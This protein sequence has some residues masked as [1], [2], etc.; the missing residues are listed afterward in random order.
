MFA[1]SDEP[2]NCAGIGRGVPVDWVP[3]HVLAKGCLIG[4][5]ERA[6]RTRP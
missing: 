5:Y 4:T 1:P 2:R 6:W 3:A